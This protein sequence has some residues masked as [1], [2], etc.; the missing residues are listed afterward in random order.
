MSIYDIDYKEKVRQLLPPDKRKPIMRAWLNALMVPMQW[1]R[2][3]WLG[4]YRIDSSGLPWINT[5]T[6]SIGDRVTYKGSA[7][8][9]IVAGN[10]GNTPTDQTKWAVVQ[11]NFIG[12]FERVLYKGNK[13][14]FEFAINKFFGTVFRQPNNVSDIFITVYP[15][16]PSVFVIGESEPFSSK[17]FTNTSSEFIVDAY[18]FSTYFNMTIFVPLAVFNALDIDPLNREKIIRNFADRYIIAGIK[19]NVLTY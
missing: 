4:D 19:Y 5:T 12:V 17:I 11:Q 6:Y 2:D 13:L 9:S 16:P 7:Y 1:L 14:L 8:E 15:K 3:L 18:S 10:L